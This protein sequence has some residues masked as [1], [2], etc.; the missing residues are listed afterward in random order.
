LP[1]E[2]V[3]GVFIQHPDPWPKRKHH[4]RR[5]IQADFLRALAQIMKPTPSADFHRPRWICCLDRRRIY[6]SP[7]FIPVYEETLLQHS[8]SITT[9]TTWF[10]AEQRRLGFDPQIHA[11]QT[12]L[13]ATYEL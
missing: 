5:L 12:H 13:G 11:I 8:T 7:A 4:R 10:E 2:S 9:S 3:E 1:A 6:S